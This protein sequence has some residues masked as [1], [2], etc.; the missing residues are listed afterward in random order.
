MEPLEI[1]TLFGTILNTGILTRIY[2]KLGKYDE[3]HES[4]ERRLEQ[5]EERIYSDKAA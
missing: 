1:L 4:H 3:K 5:I 2:F